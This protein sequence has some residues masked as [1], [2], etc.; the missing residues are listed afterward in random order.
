MEDQTKTEEVTPSAKMAQVD[1][2]LDEFE[3]KLGIPRFTDIKI[4]ANLGE[5]L[6]KTHDEL[7]QL[8]PEQCA[9]IA[10]LVVAASVTIQAA[11]NKELSHVTW[12]NDALRLGV[13]GK[14]E[15]YRGSFFQ[16]ESQ[17]IKHDDYLFKVF[18]IKSY[19]QQ[20]VDRLSFLSNTLHK[21][22]EKLEN[23]QQAKLRKA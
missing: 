7:R 17:V 23:L 16:Q 2:W 11:Y 6:S 20:R 13:A 12:A 8:T 19:A 9:E 18:R 14:T 21:F 5:Y 22:A 15:N 10:T 1:K 3:S 4:A